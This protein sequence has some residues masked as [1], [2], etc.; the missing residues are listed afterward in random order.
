MAGDGA[1]LCNIT[2]L[3]AIVEGGA[4]GQESSWRGIRWLSEHY[5]PE[6]TVVVH[7]AIRPL[8]T[9][10]LIS[11]SIRTCRK[12]GMG[13]AAVRSTDNVMMTQDGCTGRES[14]SRYA[15]RRIQTPQSYRLDYLERIHKEAIEKGILHNMDNNSLLAGMGETVF[16]SKGSDFN[17]KI[18]AVEDVEMF[19]ALYRM[20]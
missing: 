7:D 12:K 18:N 8:V 19:K 6:D 10:D 5:R 2:K 1:G 15:I 16:F 11:D 9:P 3:E 17:I 13:V 14:I 20:V 4:D